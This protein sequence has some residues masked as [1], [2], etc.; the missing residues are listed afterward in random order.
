MLEDGVSR[1][2][3]TRGVGGM[4]P[5]EDTRPVGDSLGRSSQNVETLRSRAGYCVVKGSLA[6]SLPLALGL[7]RSLA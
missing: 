5:V 7:P 6:L 3:E 4:K 2:A 1:Y